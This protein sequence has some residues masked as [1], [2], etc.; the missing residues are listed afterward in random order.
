MHLPQAAE[1]ADRLARGTAVL[2]ARRFSEESGRLEADTARFRLEE[3]TERKFFD[4]TAQ[5]CTSLL[6]L[7]SGGSSLSLPELTQLATI[8][9]GDASPLPTAIPYEGVAE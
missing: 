3:S 6:A 4:L 9:D 2:A 7:E 8:S 5:A 1:V